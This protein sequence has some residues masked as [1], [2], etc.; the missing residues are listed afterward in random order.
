M[1]Q[2][3]AMHCISASCEGYLRLLNFYFSDASLWFS[4]LITSKR[5][6]A[7][8]NFQ[9]MASRNM[10]NEFAVSGEHRAPEAHLV[11]EF[12]TLQSV[13]APDELGFV[14]ERYH[15]AEFKLIVGFS[16]LF[17]TRWS[18]SLNP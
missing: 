18:A 6:I 2:Q 1:W 12:N 4:G 3:Q 11:S 8:L 17:Y 7:I 16:M 13:E 15:D 9:D 5:N 10:H 14:F